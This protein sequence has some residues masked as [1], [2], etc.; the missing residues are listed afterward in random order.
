VYLLDQLLCLMASI[1]CAQFLTRCFF[2]AFLKI[3]AIQLIAF[4]KK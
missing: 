3:R 1:L 2:D 4:K